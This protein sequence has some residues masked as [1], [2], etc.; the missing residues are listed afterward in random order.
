MFGFSTEVAYF[1]KVLNKEDQCYL[2]T[3]V[4]EDLNTLPLLA[5]HYYEAFRNSDW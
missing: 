4:E 3:G 2:D 5:G 1:N